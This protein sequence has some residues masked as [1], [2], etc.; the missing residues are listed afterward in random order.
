[1][2]KEK[3]SP[4]LHISMVENL[5][6]E[7]LKERCPDSNSTCLIRRSTS[8]PRY[9]GSPAF[10]IGPLLYQAL[11]GDVVCLRLDAYGER[12]LAVAGNDLYAQEGD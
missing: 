11:R 7:I 2:A 8:S 5:R 3:V 1:M 10:S 12:Y 4:S 9:D 6:V